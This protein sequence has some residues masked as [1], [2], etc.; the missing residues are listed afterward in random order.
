MS[1]RMMTIQT[2]NQRDAQLAAEKQAHDAKLAAEK[3]E[4][5]EQEMKALKDRAQAHE[6]EMAASKQKQ[7]EL[8][9]QMKQMLDSQ[10]KKYRD[11]FE[12]AEEFANPDKDGRGPEG[13]AVR[14]QIVEEHDDQKAVPFSLQETVP[15]HREYAQFSSTTVVVV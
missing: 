4:R 6:A 13:A 7:D 3:Q 14:E 10:F 11:M 5:V 15:R 1:S 2:M 9:T 8:E 12:K